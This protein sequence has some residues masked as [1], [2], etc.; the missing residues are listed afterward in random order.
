MKSED[1]NWKVIAHDRNDVP[2]LSAHNLSREDAHRIA[3]KWIGRP[4]ILRVKGYEGKRQVNF[5]GWG[6]EYVDESQR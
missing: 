4:D 1:K 2:V 6:L 5:A 3:D